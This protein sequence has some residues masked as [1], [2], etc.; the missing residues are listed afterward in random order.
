M[1]NYYGRYTFKEDKDE[2]RHLGCLWA[3]KLWYWE[4]IHSRMR[5][6]ENYPQSVSEI[7]AWCIPERARESDVSWWQRR[8][9]QS[10]VWPTHTRD[11]VTPTHT[12]VCRTRG[13]GYFPKTI[14]FPQSFFSYLPDCKWPMV[15][16]L[17]V[18]GFLNNVWQTI[19]FDRK[20]S[21]HTLKEYLPLLTGCSAQCQGLRGGS[22]VT[23]SGWKWTPADQGRAQPDKW[24]ARSDQIQSTL[25]QFE[26]LDV[27]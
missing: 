9:S 25:E 3:A 7:C 5:A 2:W 26:F 8:P 18:T 6:I 24:R 20:Q 27:V 21:F 12:R 19:I 14:V 22:P 10:H 15:T 16:L 11:I 23:G 13:G 1:P 17:S 4:P